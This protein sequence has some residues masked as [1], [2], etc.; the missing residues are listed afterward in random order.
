[1][2]TWGPCMRPS[3]L[4]NQHLDH[5]AACLLAHVQAKD[6]DIII[7]TALIPG[8]KAP[9]LITKDMVNSMQAGSVTVDLAAEAGGN[10]E[11][12]T[13]GKVVKHG[14]VTCIGYTDLPARMPAQSSTLY[15][16]NIS[17]FFFS[18]THD[19]VDCKELSINHDDVAVRH[20]LIV[21][22]GA[23]M[24]PPPPVE[25]PAAKAPAPAKPPPVELTPEEKLELTTEQNKAASTS[26]AALTAFAGTAFL[27]MGAAA[28]DQ[29]ELTTML[30]VFALAVLVGRS[31]VMDVPPALH[32]PLMSVTN[33]I[34]GVTAIGGLL[35]MGGGLVPETPA[36]SAAALAVF[37]SA[38]NIGGGFLMTGRMLDMFKRPQDAP[39]FN[40]FYTASGL[41]LAAVFAAL[42]SG[43][44]VIAPRVSILPSDWAWCL[45][46]PPCMHTCL[47]SVFV[48]V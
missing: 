32:S 39:E 45:Q 11:T 29:T 22:D 7:T 10:V 24:W 20:A 9:I 27:A 25:I 8:R 46:T 41:M 1:M 37:L 30:S 18:M 6:V 28:G 3:N 31:V 44:N 21:E 43:V 12:T 13:P 35:C 47:L 33:A 19:V 38:I 16:N 14:D 36:Q 17:N 48:A 34:S 40:E 15:A 5:A 23:L 42:G 2:F 26:G 4:Y